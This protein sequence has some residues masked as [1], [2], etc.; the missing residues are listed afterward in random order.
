LQALILILLCSLF[1]WL[2]HIYI[3]VY[4]HMYVY[5]FIYIYIYIH[6]HIHTYIHIYIHTY[7]YTHIYMNI[8]IFSVMESAKDT[9]VKSDSNGP[10]NTVTMINEMIKKVINVDIQNS[11]IN[12]LDSIC[13]YIGSVTYLLVKSKGEDSLYYP[14]LEFL[15]RVYALGTVCVCITYQ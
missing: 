13:K 4:I 6:I 7:I 1:H 11:H 12:L 8:Y 5:M 2:L 10:N 15:F 14:C 3:Y 9:I